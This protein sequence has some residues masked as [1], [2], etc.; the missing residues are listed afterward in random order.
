MDDAEQK[1]GERRV[2]VLLIEHLLGLGLGRPRGFTKQAD[3]EA[4][5]D[6]VLCPRLAYMT[7]LN[8]S[9]LAT[10]IAAQPAGKA[11][12]QMPIPAHIL[13][14]AAVIQPPGDEAS[15]LIRAVFAAALGAD[16]LEQGWAPELLR[17]VKRPPRKWP[18]AEKVVLIKQEGFAAMARADDIRRRMVAGAVVHDHE[19]AFLEARD[20]AAVK[21][22][23]IRDL[24]RQGDA[25]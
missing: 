19:K 8:L 11:R 7:E 17:A 6:R 3:F 22:R 14:R 21:C 23:R 1:Q 4:M 10:E 5:V 20:A 2:R 16:A 9:A 18:N 25:A 12:D 13:E 24:A 15:P